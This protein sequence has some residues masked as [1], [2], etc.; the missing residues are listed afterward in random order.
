MPLVVSQS[1]GQ[2]GDRGTD[3]DRIVLVQ[4]EVG[5]FAITERVFQ[6]RRVVDPISWHDLVEISVC[7]QISC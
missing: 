1:Q 5:G 6:P 2:E 7:S 4:E 3:R